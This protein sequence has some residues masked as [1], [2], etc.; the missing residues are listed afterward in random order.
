MHTSRSDLEW[1][2]SELND[3]SVLLQSLGHRELAAQLRQTEEKLM[4]LAASARHPKLPIA[5]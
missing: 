2:A 1:A 5:S 3:L 4:E